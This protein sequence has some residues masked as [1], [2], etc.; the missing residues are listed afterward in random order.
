M[1]GGK[2]VS[3]TRNVL[4]VCDQWSDSFRRE[5][6]DYLDALDELLRM[7]T[8]A[9]LEREELST[10]PAED[11]DLIKAY[12]FLMESANT[13]GLGVL[14][15]LSSNLH[16]DAYALLRILYEVACLMHYG[17]VSREQKQEVLHSIFKSGLE[18]KEHGK[19]EWDLTRKATKLLKSEKPDLEEVVDM[20]NNYGAHISRAKVVLGNVT[21]L[22]DQSASEVFTSSFK[23]KYFMIGLEF[24]FSIT[25]MV[26]E[27]YLKHL[28]QFGGTPRDRH[29]DIPKL[30]K[31]FIQTIR[32][33]LQARSIGQ[34]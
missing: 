4:G 27:E 21:V 18:G 6:S 28:E 34:V 10:L 25:A 12:L 31:E 13:T 32:P 3:V 33:Q 19:A 22:G 5:F 23:D 15:L 14:R 29:R 30:C 24:L 2:T 11:Q 1:G 20:L 7:Q 9:G 8:D 16:S 17:N 26:M